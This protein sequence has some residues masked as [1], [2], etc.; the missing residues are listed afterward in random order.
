MTNVRMWM[1]QG[2]GMMLNYI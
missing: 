1:M 2:H